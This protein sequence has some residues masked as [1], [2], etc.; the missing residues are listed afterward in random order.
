ME[1]LE[2]GE[3]LVGVLGIEAGAV[4]LD[5]DDLLSVLHAAPDLDPG[6]RLLA[7]ELPRVAQQVFQDDAEQSGVSPDL[8][9]VLDL[10]GHGSLPIHLGQLPEGLPAELGQIDDLGLQGPARDPG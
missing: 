10:Y 4:V 5:V 2:G 3:E 8:E 6:L 1:T 7:A 9:T